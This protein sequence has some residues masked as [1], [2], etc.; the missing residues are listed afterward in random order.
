MILS[1]DSDYSQ[2]ST[3]SLQC[4]LEKSQ[5]T[6][7]LAYQTTRLKNH[8]IMYMYAL[9]ISGFDRFSKRTRLKDAQV[10]CTLDLLSCHNRFLF[11]KCIQK[12][13]ITFESTFCYVGLACLCHLSSL[14]K[15]LSIQKNFKPIKQFH[16]SKLIYNLEEE[17][18]K[19][20][21]KM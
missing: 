15:S 9:N 12:T 4:V 18:P 1:F 5:R 14:A 13:L 11:A 8:A 7:N 3:K 10:Q 6:I 2:S 16:C 17:S 19:S 20:R 21:S